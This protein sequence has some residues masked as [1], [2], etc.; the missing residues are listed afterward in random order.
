MKQKVLNILN[1]KN[2]DYTKYNIDKLYQAGL[3]NIINNIEF[4]YDKPYSC[5]SV[6]KELFKRGV[7]DGIKKTQS[8][9]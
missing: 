7:L 6:L 1:E 4:Y 8:I 2:L 3:E 5:E 9:I